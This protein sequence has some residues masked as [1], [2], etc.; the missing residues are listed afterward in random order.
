MSQSNR[1]LK[2]FR[3]AGSQGICNYEFPREF[4]IRYSARIDDLRKEGYNIVCERVKLPNKR[5]T[6]VYRYILIEEKK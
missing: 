6:N 5:S 4:I 3:A 2:M 1:L